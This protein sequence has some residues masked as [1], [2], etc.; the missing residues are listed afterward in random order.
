MLDQQEPL[1][2]DDV[3]VVAVDG[4]SGSGKSS[5]SRRAAQALG[6]RYLDTGAMYRAATWAVLDAGV[7]TSDSAGVAGTVGG[8]TLDVATDPAAPTVHVVRPDGS[9][10]DVTTAVRSEAVTA[11]VS[12]V[13][14]VPA[15]REQLIAAQ[16][17]L[18]VAA[19]EQGVVVEGRDIAAVVAPKAAAKIY[20][21]A[22]EAARAR[23]RSGETSAPMTT[24]AAAL[25][26][27]DRTD[28]ATTPA[29]AVP[30]AWLL[31]T[32][33]LD[34]EQAVAAVVAYAEARR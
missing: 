12:A 26:L 4:P 9:R 18:I 10:A 1:T 2:A 13:A 34:L 11:A 24:T 23:R 27:R 8:I 6:A 25:A 33:D 16:R 31:D 20:L 29:D 14:A 22:S 21:T 19:G 3:F 5:V 30:G 17:S 32:S 7:P 28:A 15:V